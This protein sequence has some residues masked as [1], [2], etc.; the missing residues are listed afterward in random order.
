MPAGLLSC[1]SQ[2]KIVNQKSLDAGLRQPIK[3]QKS[4]SMLLASSLLF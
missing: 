3:N 2:S 4:P 1:V